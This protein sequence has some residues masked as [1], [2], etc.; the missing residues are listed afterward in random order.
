M[1][2]SAAVCKEWLEAIHSNQV[3][4]VTSCL[5]W[6]E[7]LLTTLK[8][9]TLTRRARQG[10]NLEGCGWEDASWSG[11]SQGPFQVAHR[12]QGRHSEGPRR[13]RLLSAGLS[14]FDVIVL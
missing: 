1:I 2:D 8:E 9:L 6:S 7:R 13:R 10:W 5:F 14:D 3:S 11:S 4:G 12:C